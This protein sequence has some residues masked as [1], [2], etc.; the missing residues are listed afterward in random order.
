M[1]KMTMK[2]EGQRWIIT[3]RKDGTFTVWT[4]DGMGHQWKETGMTFQE[5][6][7][8]VWNMANNHDVS[9]AVNHRMCERFG[10]TFA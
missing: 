10:R 3:E 6:G 7:C 4:D 9:R 1:K 5:A 8:W 2:V